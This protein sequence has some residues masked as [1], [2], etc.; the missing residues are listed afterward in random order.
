[1][2]HI[3]QRGLWDVTVSGTSLQIQNV[4]THCWPD[5]HM[6]WAITSGGRPHRSMRRGML[7]NP[8]MLTLGWL[9]P[10]P[11]HMA[12]EELSCERHMR[13]EGALSP[14]RMSKKETA[15]RGE[16]STPTKSQHFRVQNAPAYTYN[17]HIYICMRVC[18][19][20]RMHTC[21][22]TLGIKRL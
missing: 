22:N 8:K 18:V 17:I 7:T 15:G 9:T 16:G 10:L 14:P 5:V 2:K 20:A 6:M 19:H 21:S 13:F 1:M 3:V 11:G 4:C 12:V